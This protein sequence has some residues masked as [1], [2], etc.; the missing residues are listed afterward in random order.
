MRLHFVGARIRPRGAQR[1]QVANGTPKAVAGKGVQRAVAAQE[2][3]ADPQAVT[4]IPVRVLGKEQRNSSLLVFL[5]PG[6]HCL[7]PRVE[8]AKIL[9]QDRLK[10]DEVDLLI[11]VDKPFSEPHHAHEA[12]VERLVD[13]LVL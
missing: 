7:A 10:D 6:Q 4:R 11:D 3:V 1:R 9:A 8:V 5:Q 12:A 13:R 2:H